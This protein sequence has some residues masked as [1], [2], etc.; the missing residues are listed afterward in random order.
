[1]TV[2]NATFSL[3][4]VQIDLNLSALSAPEEL[5]D[6]N[7]K[8]YYRVD[9]THAAEK[10]VAL[11]KQIGQVTWTVEWHD[12]YAENLRI[13]A[14]GKTATFTINKVQDRVYLLADNTAIKDNAM[15][16]NFVVTATVQADGSFAVTGSST[17][18]T[19]TIYFRVD[20]GASS[21]TVADDGTTSVTG[22][23]IVA[24]A[25]HS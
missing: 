15:A 2:T 12:T 22:Q 16:A 21:G 13:A 19:G 10:T 4:T 17:S 6:S 14:A 8:T 3:G 20:G 1:M 7:G 23:Q 11:S 18:S 25:S 5:S 24:T 9:A